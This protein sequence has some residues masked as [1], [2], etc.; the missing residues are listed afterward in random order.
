MIGFA[1]CQNGKEKNED[2]MTLDYPET[3]KGNVVDNYFGTQINDPYRWL[4]D[5]HSDETK[6]WVKAE[7]KV[8]FD[9]LDQISY[10]KDLENRLTELWN[11]ERIGVPFKRGDYV[12]YYKNDGLQNQSVIYRYKKDE[13]PENA[14]VFLDPNSFSKDGSTSLD[15]P[16]FSEDGDLLA[17]TISEGGSDWR[18][19][20]VIDTEN[21]KQVGDT[22]IDVKFSGVSWKDNEGFFYSSYDAPKES[23]VGS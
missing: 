12:Y 14:K 7:N 11:Y 5:D 9:Y 3:K 13:D 20:I 21:Q 2:S 6:S 8:T 15:Q 10:R 23:Q 19:V 22:L 18:K 17:Y 16:S 1:A 4:E